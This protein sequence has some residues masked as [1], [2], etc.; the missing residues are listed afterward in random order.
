VPISLE[1]EATHARILADP[2]GVLEEWMANPDYS[3]SYLIIT[4]SQKAEIDALGI[5]PAG[6]LDAIEATLLTSPR[7]EALFHT[8]DA[9]VFTLVDTEVGS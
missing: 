7:F 3:A 2:V 9:T 5:M 6:S 1:P 4:A 8:D